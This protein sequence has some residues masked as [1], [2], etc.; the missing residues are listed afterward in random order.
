[1]PPIGNKI[2]GKNEDYH[3]TGSGHSGLELNVSSIPTFASKLGLPL[4]NPAPEVSPQPE[5]HSTSIITTT[6]PFSKYQ[7]ITN[8]VKKKKYEINCETEFSL[9]TKCQRIIW[10]CRIQTSRERRNT[11]KKHGPGE[12]RC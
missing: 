10:K 4:P 5:M 3:E 1:M 9:Q 6:G 11:Q 2:G 8:D 7:D 12:S